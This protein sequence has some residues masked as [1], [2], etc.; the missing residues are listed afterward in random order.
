MSAKEA[1]L[2]IMKWSCISHGLMK[3]A[4]NY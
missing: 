2:V 1:I 3:D 4:Q